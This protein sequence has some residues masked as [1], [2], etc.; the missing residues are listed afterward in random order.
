CHLLACVPGPAPG[1]SSDPTDAN[2]APA[3]PR[4]TGPVCL[5]DTPIRPGPV[6][7]HG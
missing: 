6:S 4:A 7:G 1:D 3:P 5:C 2:P